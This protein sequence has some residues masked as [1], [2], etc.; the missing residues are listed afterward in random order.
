[1]K[2]LITLS[3]RAA[4]NRDIAL[5]DQLPTAFAGPEALALKD[6]VEGELF[7]DGTL[8]DLGG[9]IGQPAPPEMFCN[10]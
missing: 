6:F 10:L 4:F 3:H 9:L 5:Q 8:T 1:M 7:H 2:W